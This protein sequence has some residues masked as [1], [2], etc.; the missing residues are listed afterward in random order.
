M[1]FHI[2]RSKLTFDDFTNFRFYF[3]RV[4]ISVMQTHKVYAS[5][6]VVS[7]RFVILMFLVSLGSDFVDESLFFIILENSAQTK[8]TGA[9]KAICKIVEVIIVNKSKP[10][11][12]NENN[13]LSLTG[14]N[15]IF[16]SHM[17]M[18]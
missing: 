9:S 10:E 16:D 2:N 13:Q 7:S 4:S 8:A 6:P 12:M 15:F 5:T 3:D 11:N 18:I 1:L 17:T 14:S